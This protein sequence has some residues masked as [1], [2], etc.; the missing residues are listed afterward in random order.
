MHQRG[1]TDEDL[2]SAAR[3][4]GT[5]AAVSR[6]MPTDQRLESR[7]RG[8]ADEQPSHPRLAAA[9]VMLAV[10]VLLILLAVSSP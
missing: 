8:A 2:A 7:R 3:I 10:A 1:S 5:P 6:Q 4:L 9:M